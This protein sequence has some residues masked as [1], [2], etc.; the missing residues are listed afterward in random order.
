MYIQTKLNEHHMEE[1][2]YK[3]CDIGGKKSKHIL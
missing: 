1:E 2:D 3:Y